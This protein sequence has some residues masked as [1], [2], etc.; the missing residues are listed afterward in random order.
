MATKALCPGSRTMT[1]FR[2]AHATCPSCKRVKRTFATGRI[3]PHYPPSNCAWLVYP[4]PT[5]FPVPPSR[6]SRK[7][8]EGSRYCRQHNRPQEKPA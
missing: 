8:I 4:R 6:C 2:D 7:A 3:V 1:N 5:Y